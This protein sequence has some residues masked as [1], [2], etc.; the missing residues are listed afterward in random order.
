MRLVVA[1]SAGRNR[2]RRQLLQHA[3][4]EPLVEAD[5][6]GL[7]VALPGSAQ[8][9]V[10][11]LLPGDQIALL[12]RGDRGVAGVE[13]HGEPDDQHA[14]EQQD[15][16]IGRQAEVVAEGGPVRPGR[17][18]PPGIEPEMV[19]QRQVVACIG[20]PVVG[21]ID[22]HA[23]AAGIAL[24]PDG[25]W[26]LFSMLRF[27]VGFG[28]MAATTA[29]NPLIVEITPTRYRTFVSSMMVVPVALGTMFAAMISA[30][31][32]P[33]IGW[34]GVAATGAMPIVTSQLPG[35]FIPTPVPFIF[36]VPIAMAPARPLWFN[37]VAT[38]FFGAARPMASGS[39][40]PTIRQCPASGVCLPPAARPKLYPVS[41]ILTRVPRPWPSRPTEN[42]C[43]S[44]T[45]LETSRHSA[46]LLER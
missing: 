16:R 2:G 42:F 39:I 36:G 34:R 46:F 10:A 28:S 27:V 21:R 15:R 32:L 33:V 25:A 38:A 17:R 1:V 29:Q 8:L 3:G 24:I 44:S 9:R 45:P 37:W 19:L 6:G 23:R 22:P 11:R 13:P 31:L 5:S 30:S 40:T 35:F 18:E 12:R 43:S 14:G 26:I 7:R 20:V 4:V 41:S